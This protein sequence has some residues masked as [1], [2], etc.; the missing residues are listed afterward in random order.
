MAHTNPHPTSN[1]R[2][3]L[4]QL[5]DMDARSA[6]FANRVRSEGESRNIHFP[7]ACRWT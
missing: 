2:P 1:S 5:R 6:S 7:H 4:G 3:R